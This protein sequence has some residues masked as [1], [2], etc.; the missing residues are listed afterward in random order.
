MYMPKNLSSMPKLSG[1]AWTTPEMAWTNG[2]FGMDASVGEADMGHELM[3]RTRPCQSCQVWRGPTSALA[4][5]TAMPY[6][7][8]RKN[9]FGM[10]ASMPYLHCPCQ[11]C[12]LWHGRIVHAKA[13][14]SFGMDASF[15]MDGVSFGMDARCNIRLTGICNFK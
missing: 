11:S 5:T 8:I 7:G 6:L 13:E 14:N 4:W 12:Q 10:D 9:S 2:S 1:M 3:A 15:G